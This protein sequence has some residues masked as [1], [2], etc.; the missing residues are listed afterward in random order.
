MLE[1][2]EKQLFEFYQD[3]SNDFESHSSQHPADY[4]DNLHYFNFLPVFWPFITNF[5]VKSD[6]I[7][8]STFP[9]SGTTWMQQIV[10]LIMTQDFNCQ[11]P[12]TVRFPF[13]ELPVPMKQSTL[14]DLAQQTDRPRLMKTHLPANLLPK[15]WQ[16]GKLIYIYRNA[17]DCAV[18]FYHHQRRYTN[19][20]YQ[21]GFERYAK[22]F[23]KG[24]GELFSCFLLS[25]EFILN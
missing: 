8:I 23:I 15:L 24:K 22:D 19:G 5:P 25:I 4:A 11:V 3:L 20:K 12:I 6:D 14:I 21:H 13:L 10:Y 7:L 2:N 17:K 16:N 18:S 1:D 9:K